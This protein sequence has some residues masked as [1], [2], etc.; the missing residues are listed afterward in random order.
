MRMRHR[1]FLFGAILLLLVERYRCCPS[2]RGRRPA[3]ALEDAPELHDVAVF[4]DPVS[5][6]RSTG[7]SAGIHVLELPAPRNGWLILEAA[8][9]ARE[10][11]E[12][13]LARLLDPLRDQSTG[14]D[15]RATVTRFG[16]SNDPQRQFGNTSAIL[17]RAARHQRAVGAVLSASHE[18]QL[19]AAVAQDCQGDKQA[20]APAKEGGN[21]QGRRLLHV[22]APGTC[23]RVVHAVGRVQVQGSILIAANDACMGPALRATE[24]G[25]EEDGDQV[26][27][28]VQETQQ[29]TGSA[30]LAVARPLI[31]MSS[32]YGGAFAHF[33]LEALP[34]LAHALTDESIASSVPLVHVSLPPDAT[35]PA[36]FQVQ[37][38]EA[39]GVSRDRVRFGMLRVDR[40]PVYFPQHVPCGVPDLVRVRLLADLTRRGLA[41]HSADQFRRRHVV[42]VERR[43]PTRRSWNDSVHAHVR[44]ALRAPVVFSGSEPFKEQVATFGAAR[45]VIAA[46]GAALAL[47]MFCPRD[48]LIVEVGSA[49]P[50][51]ASVLYR[52]VALGLGLRHVYVDE[53]ALLANPRQALAAVLP[54]TDHM[55]P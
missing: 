48:A 38:L 10:S 45:V 54:L 9:N 37:A 13:D 36:A 35:A 16:P 15:I 49:D 28:R 21:D 53:A 23:P 44:A 19:L 50:A 24:V 30:V 31:V 2:E 18:E 6:S 12:S 25:D 22:L 14:C 39:L 20:P 29:H 52:F 55:E 17:C 33:L 27:E 26:S 51:R 46:H 43:A 40:A 47:T 41:L 8:G 5:R 42:Y 34:R 4:G 11:E 3:L 7:L 1:P 32:P